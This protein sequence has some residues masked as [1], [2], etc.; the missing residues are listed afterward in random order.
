MLARVLYALGFL[1]GPL[2]LW[3]M[4]R[5]HRRGARSIAA[6]E[7]ELLSHYFDAELLERVRV[8]EAGRVRLI[9]GGVL[10]GL[11]VRVVR[12]AGIT[13]GELVVLGPALSREQRL[14]VLFHELVHVQQFAALGRARFCGAYVGG[15]WRCGRNYYRI[16]LEVPAYAF[17]RRFE[18]GESFRVDAVNACVGDDQD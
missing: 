13:L 8:C 17:Q 11:G 1:V 2:W 3:W 9:G 5:V 16:P 10:R 7:L 14:S 15:W 6:P 18:A 12:P 4:R